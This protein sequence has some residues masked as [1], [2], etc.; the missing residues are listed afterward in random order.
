MASKDPSSGDIIIHELSSPEKIKRS[1]I[2]SSSL[3]FSQIPKKR[4]ISLN[5]FLTSSNENV[6]E[7][8]AEKKSKCSLTS[9]D[10]SSIEYASLDLNHG[11]R[12]SRFKKTHASLRSYSTLSN[13]NASYASIL[14]LDKPMLFQ[15]I[16]EKCF[17][18]DYTGRSNYIYRFSD[19]KLSEE[20]L[21]WNYQ[22]IRSCM[23]APHIPSDFKGDL[24][25]LGILPQEGVVLLGS[26]QE[27]SS[28]KLSS[29]SSG[30]AVVFYANQSSKGRG[31]SIYLEVGRRL[32]DYRRYHY[33]SSNS[34]GSIPSCFYYNR[35]SLTNEVACPLTLQKDSFSLTPESKNSLFCLQLLKE[36][37]G[38]VL[39]SSPFAK[40]RK[41]GPIVE[42]PLTSPQKSTRWKIYLTTAER[43]FLMMNERGVASEYILFYFF[44]FIFS[45]L[46]V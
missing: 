9:A 2:L 7:V 46:Y 37:N 29:V 39:A 42:N 19:S 45:F 14:L 43:I 24:I 13:K 8:V 25:L 31:L 40:K 11:G 6:F 21:S 5:G 17:V 44:K 15:S 16:K 34:T 22:L 18:I 36:M 35:N 20:L 12:N 27:A 26:L 28:Q 32:Q 1:S 4:N 23:S 38:T 3:L 41:R 10:H 33:F 30:N